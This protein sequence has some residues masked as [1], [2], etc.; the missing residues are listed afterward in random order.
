MTTECW[1]IAAGVILVALLAVTSR[2][3]QNQSTRANPQSAS[4]QRTTA[5]ARAA[6]ETSPPQ[7]LENNPELH[8][9][10]G[11]SETHQYQLDELQTWFNGFLAIFTLALVVVGG[12][13]A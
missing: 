3:E 5:Q 7:G 1:R 9:A 6:I 10:Q 8:R 4:G 2:A 11:N 12:I 13:Q